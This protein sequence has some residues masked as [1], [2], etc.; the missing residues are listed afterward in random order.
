M[1]IL[2]CVEGTSVDEMKNQLFEGL[3]GG[4]GNNEQFED[5]EGKPLE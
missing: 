5:E 2:L 1:P 4:K 3:I